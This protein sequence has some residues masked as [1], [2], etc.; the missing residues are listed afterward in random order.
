M[1]DPIAT[2]ERRH[3]FRGQDGPGATFDGARRANFD[4]R[5]AGPARRLSL[6]IDEAAASAGGLIGGFD[7][8]QPINALRE[9]TGD[10]M[11][12]LSARLGPD[13][14]LLIAEGAADA[15]IAADPGTSH[16][17]VDI[18][19]RNVAIELAGSEAVDVLNTGCPLDLGDIAFPAGTATRTVF[20]KAEIILMRRADEDGAP[21]YRIEC[22][23]SFGRYLHAHLADS[24]RLL[25]V[26]RT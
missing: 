1:S 5:L 10:G 6:R 22:W 17:L 24:A 9:T 19:H 15:A 25:G 8:G 20:A 12:H 21:L 14:W 16:T 23:R 18:S 7:I 2:A 13:E 11:V 4:M 26:D 3:V